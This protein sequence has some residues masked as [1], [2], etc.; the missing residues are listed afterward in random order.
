VNVTHCGFL[1]G[2][3]KW[4]DLGLKDVIK[5]SKQPT[6]FALFSP[7]SL[8]ICSPYPCILLDTLAISSCIQKLG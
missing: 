2:E 6:I 8:I 7:V 3:G 4:H 5:V 1:V